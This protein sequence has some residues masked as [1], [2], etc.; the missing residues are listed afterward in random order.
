MHLYYSFLSRF[1]V[2]EV[3]SESDNVLSIDLENSDVLKD[4]NSIFITAMIKWQGARGSNI[5]GTSVYKKL[6]KVRFF[7]IK[8]TKYLQTSML[9]LKNDATESLTFLHLPERHQDTLDELHVLMRRSPRVITETNALESKFLEYQATSDDE[10]PAHV[11]EDDRPMCIDHIWH[12]IS[13]QIDLYS[14]QP[15]FK[16]LA[17]FA[18]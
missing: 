7:F 8:C 3:I 4:F 10:L 14:G 13:K 17:E 16:H 2:S 9:V 5:I 6:L 15:R 12:H 11:D 18:K 1:T